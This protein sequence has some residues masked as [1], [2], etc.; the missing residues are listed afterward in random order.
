MNLLSSH[1]WCEEAILPSR[2]FFSALLSLLGWQF[3]LWAVL[4]CLFCFFHYKRQIVWMLAL[5]T[6]PLHPSQRGSSSQYLHF[7]CHILLQQTGLSEVVLK[8]YQVPGTVPSGKPP[9]SEPYRTVPCRTMQWKSAISVSAQ[10]VAPVA[11][12]SDLLPEARSLTAARHGVYGHHR[13]P[14]RVRPS[15][16]ILC[17]LWFLA[18]GVSVRSLFLCSHVWQHTVQECVSVFMFAWLPGYLRWSSVKWVCLE[19]AAHL[20]LDWWTEL[21]GFTNEALDG[22]ASGQSSHTSRHAPPPR[23]VG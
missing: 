13:T 4:S 6:S 16:Y 1:L 8:K 7:C 14:I 12:V 19:A 3:V 11:C 2:V 10:L 20:P 23:C 22:N 9:K 18:S 5:L 17:F 15:L 21:C